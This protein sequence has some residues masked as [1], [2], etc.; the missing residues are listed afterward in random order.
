MTALP[1]MEQGNANKAHAAV[2]SLVISGAITK[3]VNKLL[4]AKY[5]GFWDADMGDAGGILIDGLITWFAVY[6]TPT[7]NKG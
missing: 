2:G 4:A 1:P 3:I 5:P 7:G 6:F